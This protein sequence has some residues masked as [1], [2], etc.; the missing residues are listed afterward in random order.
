MIKRFLPLVVIAL[1]MAFAF[2]FGLDDYITLEALARREQ[3]LKQLV[4][5]YPLLLALAYVGLYAVVV[6][7]SLPVATVFT[8]AGGMIFGTWL[9][10]AFAVIGASLGACAIFLATKTAFGDALK[11]KAGPRLQQFEQGFQRDAVFYLLFVRFVPIFPFF[12]VNILPAMVG[13]RFLI[14]ALTTAVGI[15]PGTFVY[16][17]IGNGI[18]FVFA[19]GKTPDLSIITSPQVL[20]P[21]GRV[22]PLAYRLS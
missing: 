18:A 8:L 2:A 22:E 21:L 4:A 15:I 6:A 11:Q 7:L 19:Q 17:S 3:Q 16:A 12:L 1:A 13:V 20:L 14:F 5:S 9:G 10:G